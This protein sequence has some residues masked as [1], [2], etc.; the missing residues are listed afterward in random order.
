M[1]IRDDVLLVVLKG[2]SV[3]FDILVAFDTIRVIAVFCS[4]AMT[5]SPAG[6]KPAWIV[7]AI[8]ESSGSTVI[9]VAR[10]VAQDFAGVENTLLSLI[11][12]WPFF[13]LCG[14]KR[15]SILRLLFI[16]RFAN[17]K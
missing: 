11:C 5:C 16:G 13:W 15:P 2:L 14:L 6:Y 12:T 4:L 3:G 7:L 9:V 1:F 10:I 8:S 17:T